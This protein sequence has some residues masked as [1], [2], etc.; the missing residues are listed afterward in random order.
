MTIDEKTSAE[1]AKENQTTHNP[2][3]D[4]QEAKMSDETNETDDLDSVE[5]DIEGEIEE[6]EA[7]IEQLRADLLEAQ[8]LAEKNQE[9]VLRA[10]A[11][12]ENLNRRMER[13]VENAHK[14]AMERF[15]QGLLPVIDSLEMGLSAA[16]EEGAN[17]EKVKEGSE[18]TLKMFADT[19]KKFGIEAIDPQGEEFNPTYHQAMSMQ[20]HG[21]SKPN[22]VLAVMQKGYTLQGRLIRP[23][24][25]VVSKAASGKQDEA[26]KSDANGDK[27]G[28]KIDE[29]A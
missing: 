10:R 14:Y 29:Q 15:V 18:L 28:T 22:T 2:N 5:Q 23:A 25:V 24:M 26:S 13:E 21:D 4:G 1:S 27:I 9:A 8:E 16:S 17:L 12:I 7:E 11:D 20:E 3:A 19:A 6:I